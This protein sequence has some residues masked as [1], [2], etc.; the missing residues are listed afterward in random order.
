MA[1]RRW[2]RLARPWEIQE[3]GFAFITT[4]HPCSQSCGQG[5]GAWH[6]PPRSSQHCRVLLTGRARARSHVPF[7][8]VVGRA[9]GGK[10]MFQFTSP[11][12]GNLD[13]AQPQTVLVQKDFR[14][15]T[16]SHF[17]PQVGTFQFNGVSHNAASLVEL[18][19]I[20]WLCCIMGYY[21][22]WE[23]CPTVK[24]GDV[25]EPKAFA[26]SARISSESRSFLLR[27]L[28]KPA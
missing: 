10:K 5:E 28:I 6:D 27:S 8:Y 3:L 18:D 24:N 17:C 16:C 2:G 14:G 21:L 9:G 19:G 26:I 12:G 4:H 23:P 15:T 7:L 20:L 22:R 13:L 25:K 11:P 1:K